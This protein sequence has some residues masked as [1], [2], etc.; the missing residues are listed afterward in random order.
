MA[1]PGGMPRREAGTWAGKSEE[2]RG[3]LGQEGRGGRRESG[4]CIERG[5]KRELSRRNQNPRPRNTEEGGDREPGPGSAL[6]ATGSPGWTAPKW[7]LEARGWCEFGEGRNFGFFPH[8]E[9]PSLAVRPGTQGRSVH[10]AFCG[11][12]CVV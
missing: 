4:P 12:P 1:G 11:F 9:T 5:R 2:G 3:N 8:E 10:V 7:K 6:E